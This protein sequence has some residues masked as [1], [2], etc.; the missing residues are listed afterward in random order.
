[1]DYLAGPEEALCKYYNQWKPFG[2][3]ANV[4]EPNE[5]FKMQYCLY[6]KMHGLY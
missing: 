4:G 1:M 5:T 6:N 3:S 2:G